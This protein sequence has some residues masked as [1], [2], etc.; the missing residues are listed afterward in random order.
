MNQLKNNIQI[1]HKIVAVFKLNRGVK[2][3]R[4]FSATWKFLQAANSLFLSPFFCYFS[5][6][7]F[8]MAKEEEI[9][10]NLLKVLKGLNKKET[11][12]IKS[13]FLKLKK[14]YVQGKFYSFIAA[15]SCH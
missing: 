7:I 6:K 1:S 12:R 9:S 3:F 2:I 8:E 15:V 5:F 13:R 4:A 11:D 14:N 10:E